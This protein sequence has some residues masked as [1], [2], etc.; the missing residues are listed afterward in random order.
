MSTS[1]ENG[2]I[3]QQTNICETTDDS[4]L[5]G[6][7]AEYRVGIEPW[8]VCVQLSFISSM[9]SDAEAVQGHRGR[10]ALA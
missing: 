8:R 6:M 9:E 3:V 7:T 2:Q 5:C 4:Q 10:E 1:K